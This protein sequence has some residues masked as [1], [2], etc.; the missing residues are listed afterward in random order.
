MMR[1]TK[2]LEGLVVE[3]AK[4]FDFGVKIFGRLEILRVMRVLGHEAGE[5]LK[6]FGVGWVMRSD[7]LSMRG[8]ALCLRSLFAPER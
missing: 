8:R 4:V 3:I 6:A 7:L 1:D 5:F 2:V